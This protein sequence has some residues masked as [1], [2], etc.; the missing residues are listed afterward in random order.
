MEKDKFGAVNNLKHKE[1]QCLE[2]QEGYGERLKY[3]IEGD[4]CPNCSA[5]M[6]RALSTT[7][8]IGETAIN[9]ATK[10]VYLPPSMSNQ[11]QRIMET[12][13]PGVKLVLAEPK[14]SAVSAKSL[15]GRV[16]CRIEG[17]FCPSCSAKMERS[18]SSTPGF[19]ETTINYA[20]KTVLLPP[21]M[22]QE[23]QRIMENIE[24]G[25]KLVAV[26]NPKDQNSN[27]KSEG[28]TVGGKLMRIIVAGI[29]LAIGLIYSSQWHDTS[30][31]FIEYAVFL[32]AYGLVGYD[33]LR[34]AF[35]NILRGSVFDENF[36]MVLATIGAISIHQLSEAVGVMLFYS[37]GEYIQARAVD[38]SR[39]SI[40]ALM[41]IRPDYANIINQLDVVK[42]DPEDVQI[43]Q[44]I[45]I[46]PGEKVPL[47]GEV[48][49]GNSFLDTS[50]LTGESVPR[51]VG[52][53]DTV[54][55][56]TINQSGVLTV[57]VTREFA[58]SSVQ[59][60]L[61][62]V[63]N[64]GARKANTE[65]F[66]TTFARYY[67]PLVVIVA[68]VIAF[69]P[70]LIF[71]GSL[72]QWLYRALTIL[73]ISCPCALVVSIPLGYFGGIGGASKQGILVKGA[74][75]LEALT[76][77]RTVVFDKTGTLTQGV[78]EV[79]Q[80]NPAH[81]FSENEL[82]E[83]AATAEVHSCHPIAQSIRDKYGKNVDSSII[84]DYQEI[85][86]KGI[87]VNLS[88]E[89]VLVGKAALLEEEGIEI[90][91]E[92]G[93]RTGTTVYLAVNDRY[94]G[95]IL[96]SDKLK[97]GA[98]AAVQTL[99]KLGV[100]TVMLTG[101]HE[102][103][104]K[105][106]SEELGIAE[107]HA[108]LLPEDKVAWLEK[109]I[110]ESKRHDKGK[111]AFVGDGINDAPVLTQADIGVAMGGLG[112]DAAIEA[113]DVVIM[114]DQPEKLLSAISIAR[115]TKVI[116]WENIIFAM[117]I[118]LGFIVLGAFGAAN[119]WEAVFADVGVALLAILNA[120]RV[121]NYLTNHTDKTKRKQYT[122]FSG[123]SAK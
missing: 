67:T 96:I 82:L 83:I 49:N 51:R 28:S 43:G 36:L 23:A 57:R 5:K 41:D 116:I 103:V 74:N 113:A 72:N 11:A 66:I 52:T 6:E 101:D 93:D 102:S 18:L 32:S 24:H 71:D 64:A 78:F 35:R 110:E 99:N 53:G 8:G 107:F 100:K 76:K 98:F 95:Y 119:M 27:Q 19:G 121:R 14:K 17:E 90:I 10:T 22:I 20:A 62:L 4:F 56:G 108:D 112:S 55:A 58:D 59:K 30:W 73:V 75:F 106:V 63:E 70:P 118:K 123:N 1:K 40:E 54:L 3:R 105:S 86:G 16:K 115:Y 13:E 79:V 33:V 111:V 21:E 15:A 89:T 50:A 97:A 65:K 91:D 38:R 2:D 45:L 84:R 61:D 92:P 87:Q 122:E 48:L 46:R 109:L 12:I 60:I 9:Y 7:P 104:A 31:E 120:T 69:L 29:L 34:T 37:V 39:Q 26:E 47:D 77:V 114:E 85:G 94:A 81:G 68:L 44:C 42:V 80:I 88:G 25:V 117:A